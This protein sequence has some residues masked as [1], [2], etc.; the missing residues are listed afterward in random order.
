[1]LLSSIAISLPKLQLYIGCSGWSY[2]A[3]S[4]HFY[5]AKLESK[6]YLEYYSKVFGYVEID[7]SFYRT[8]STLMTS[9][10][11]KVTSDNFKFTAKIPQEVTHKKRLG[12]SIDNDTHC[13]TRILSLHMMSLE[14]HTDRET[15]IGHVSFSKDSCN[16]RAPK[17]S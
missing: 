10:W 7:S 11:A 6:N 2:R 16:N 1:M 12:Q 9:R 4:G 3:W 13:F 8:P 17:S 14:A 5:P 15:L